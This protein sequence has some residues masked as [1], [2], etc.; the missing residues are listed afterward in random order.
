MKR[1]VLV[2][3]VFI[4]I[5]LLVGSCHLNEVCPAYATAEQ[6]EEEQKA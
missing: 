1:K 3:L 2:L 4:S 6:T 5:G